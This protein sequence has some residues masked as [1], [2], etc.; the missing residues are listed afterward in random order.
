V[1]L[2]EAEA[3]GRGI[4]YHVFAPRF[5]ENDRAICDGEG[6]GFAKV[7]TRKGTG[8]IVGAAVVHM[9]AG[10]LLAELTVA[11][12]CGLSR[13]KLAS[14]KHV[15]QTLSELHRALGGVYLLDEITPRLRSILTPVFARL[16]RGSHS[17]K[18][19]ALYRTSRLRAPTAGCRTEFRPLLFGTLRVLLMVAALRA[20]SPLAVELRTVSASYHTDPTQLE[21]IREGLELAIK[22]DSHP[23]NLLALAQL[24]F[25]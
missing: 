19:M 7:L 2:S 25:I 13:P 20:Q 23:G 14:G 6:A 11:K 3:Q 15:Y 17:G 8:K 9:H 12:K 5:S 22:T 10:E 24:R 1:R 21:R 4:P 16:R 18:A